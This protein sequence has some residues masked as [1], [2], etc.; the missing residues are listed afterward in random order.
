MRE[1]ST[2]PMEDEESGGAPI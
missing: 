2:I 1:I